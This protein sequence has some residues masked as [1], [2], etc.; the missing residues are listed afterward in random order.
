[1]KSKKNS[2]RKAS[3]SSPKAK[4]KK[5]AP[6]KTAKTTKPIKASAKSPK[7]TKAVKAGAR[8]KSNGPK[9]KSK[10][11][12]RKGTQDASPSAS[13][14]REAQVK[15]SR[16]ENGEL[17]LLRPKSFQQLPVEKPFGFP[18]EIPELPENYHRD[19]LVLMSKEPEYLFSYWEITPELLA[20]KEMEKHDDEEYREVFKLNWPA[21]SLFDLNFALLPISFASRRWY[22]RSPFPGLTFHADLGWLGNH[23]H[24]IPIISSNDAESPENWESTVQ[25]L[26]DQGETLAYTVRIAQ[27]IG[28]SEHLQLE[29]ARFAVTDWNMSSGIFSSSSS[30]RTAQAPSEVKR[31]R[32]APA[33]SLRVEAQLKPGS[34]LRVDG[35]ELTA[36]HAGKVTATL[37]ALEG[38][39]TVELTVSGG[40]R[41]AYTYDLAAAAK[42]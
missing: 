1:M 41:H 9:T 23:G 29:E 38:A 26:K 7:A 2:A 39:L 19:R 36:D 17:K 24:F 35:R 10:S 37:A 34:R 33:S 20:E 25:R 42:S 16:F 4:Q 30:T 18:D 28:A 11:V 32:R 27:P 13:I 14:L 5:T 15:V 40:E 22:L 6:P 21:R 3:P 8:A 31:T 12:K